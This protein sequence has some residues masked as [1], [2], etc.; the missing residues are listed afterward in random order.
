MHRYVYMYTYIYIYIY[1]CR[2][3]LC[4]NAGKCTC[5]DCLSGQ[6]GLHMEP[7]WSSIWSSLGCNLLGPQGAPGPSGA[8]P[9]CASLSFNGPGPMGLPWAF[10]GWAILAPLGPHGPGS[11]G[12]LGPSWAVIGSA[13]LGPPGPSWA[14]P[15]W[16]PWARMA[17]LGPRGR[18]SMAPPW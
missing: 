5:L 15:E 8:E 13:L 1:M 18:A 10:T 9:N 11:N 2:V 17:P 16:A 6:A 4:F 14:G 12:P 3:L 7:I